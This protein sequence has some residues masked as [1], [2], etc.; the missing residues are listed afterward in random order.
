MTES[1]RERGFTIIEVVLVLAIAGLI[2]LMVFMALPALQ[3]SQRDTARKN[4]VGI[5][6]AALTNYSS[7]NRGQLPY[8]N[9]VSTVITDLNGGTSGIEPYLDGLSGNITQVTFYNW[10]D[11]WQDGKGD[12]DPGH[13]FVY[14]RAQCNTDTTAV[15][16]T[17]QGAA[18]QSAVMIKLET[19]GLYC[20]TV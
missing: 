2:F 19:G 12:G 5:V 14:E 4:D 20:Q 11:A 13:I 8:A 1:N 16:G 6:A 9:Q 18:R 17:L 3:K 15:K 7:N 10:H